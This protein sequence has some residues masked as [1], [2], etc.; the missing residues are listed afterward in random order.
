MPG[1][2]LQRF[3][4]GAAGYERF[5]PGDDFVGKLLVEIDDQISAVASER[6]GEQRLS[7]KNVVWNSSGAQL[8]TCA[9]QSF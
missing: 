6:V 3:A 1:D 9:P 5:I 8:F 7:V 2:V 4:S